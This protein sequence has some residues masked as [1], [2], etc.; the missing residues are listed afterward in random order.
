[1]PRHVKKKPSQL[2]FAATIGKVSRDAGGAIEMIEFTEYRPNPAA[3]T[4]YVNKVGGI[5]RVDRTL[6]KVTFISGTPGPGG[7]HLYVESASLLW[8]PNRW[9]EAGDCFRW[10][11]S[12]FAKGTFHGAVRDGDGGR[13]G[14][15]Q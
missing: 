4:V 8:E 9:M 10:A 15:T 2:P 14:R 12:E 3:P 13:R 5:Y 6:I 1:M 11:I 7:S